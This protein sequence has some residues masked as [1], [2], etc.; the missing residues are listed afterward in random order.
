V[1]GLRRDLSTQENRDY[2]AGVDRRAG[3]WRATDPYKFCNRWLFEDELPDDYPYDA[4]FPYSI[5]D[6]VR[7]FPW[8]PKRQEPT[9]NLT[10]D[11]LAG[12][13]PGTESDEE[14]NRTLEEIE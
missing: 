12:K 10:L 8:L 6:G 1:S 3:L 7:M 2:W 14:T 5:V 11:D 13:W 9:D 4:M